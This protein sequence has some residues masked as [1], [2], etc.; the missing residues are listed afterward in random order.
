M[1]TRLSP[2]PLATAPLPP[3]EEALVIQAV[4][5][6]AAVPFALAVDGP[7]S[8]PVQLAAMPTDVQ[9]K[10][11]APPAMTP[12]AARQPQELPSDSETEFSD[13][14]K[15]GDTAILILERAGV[16]AKQA[17]A[18]YR[19]VRKIYNLRRIN[20]G[21]TYHVHLDGNG[22][23]QQ[24]IYEIDH[25]QRLV[26][27]RDD[28][29]FRGQLKVI[30]YARSE[31]VIV[32]ELSD[33][34][35]ATLKAQ[36][37]STRLIRDFADIFAW[38]VDFATDLRQGDSFRLL[39]EEHE[40]KGQTAE[41]HRILAAE[42]INRNRKLQ[43][44]Y[45]DYK[46][47]GGYY[48]PDGSSMQGMFLRSPLRYTRI[49]SR[50]TRRRFHPILK[51]YR[52]HLGIDYAAPRGTPVRSVAKGKVEWFG[53]K[54]ANGK[55]VVIRHQNAYKSYYLHLSRYA[56]GLRRH[57]SVSQGQIIGYVGSTGM[58]TGPHL[59]FRLAKNGKY[60]NPLKHRSIEGPRMPKS[61]MADFR[62]HTKT[63][64]SKLHQVKLAMQQEPQTKPFNQ[65]E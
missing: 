30:P 10:A 64:L 41:Y 21:Q 35:Y 15:K 8:I 37:E 54:G 36:G 39:I 18:L 56:P 24:F 9:A 62:K 29:G 5:S 7:M 31:R 50:F 22:Q 43:T 13:K 61:A 59:D 28:Q 38:S 49:S 45:Y 25:R 55:M 44:V 57:K 23:I 53:R 58:S 48:R 11:I 65:M 52:P 47:A 12:H 27:I 20:V 32:G 2:K 19:A 14:V 4:Q 34:I 3:P 16:D 51:R 26:V 17:M 46:N 6:Q 40:R 1:A 63:M 42:L 33:S 60:I